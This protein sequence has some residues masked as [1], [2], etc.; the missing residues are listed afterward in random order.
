MVI[1][2]MDIVAQVERLIMTVLTINHQL[3]QS[4]GSTLTLHPEVQEIHQS[5]SGPSSKKFARIEMQCA[6]LVV[7]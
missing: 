4:L 7:K 1:T 2:W 5:L 6:G 3:H